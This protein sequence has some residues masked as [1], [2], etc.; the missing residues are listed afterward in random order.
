MG[1]G[2]AGR[3]HVLMELTH[4]RSGF[5]PNLGVTLKDYERGEIPFSQTSAAVGN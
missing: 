5:D 4:A 1:G 3:F 2:L